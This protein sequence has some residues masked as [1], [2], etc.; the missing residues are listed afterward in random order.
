MGFEWSTTF[1]V[2]NKE[3]DSHHRFIF[4]QMNKI[5][6]AIATDREHQV[7]SDALAELVTYSSYHFGAEEALFEINNYPNAE[8]HVEEHLK[9]RA[10]LSE[11]I[12]A[13]D[14]GEK[15]VGLELLLL[16]RSWFRDHIMSCD[17]RYIPYVKE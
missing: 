17:K 7:V 8:E 16:L 12:A 15:G 11:L 1:T 14:R 4:E 13:I 9:F 2:E 5:Q 3:L 10:S 6:E